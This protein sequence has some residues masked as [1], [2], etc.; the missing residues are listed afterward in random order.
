M[1]DANTDPNNWTRVG[2]GR[3]KN[4]ITGEVLTGQ[5]GNPAVRGKYSSG[6]G[7]APAQSAP[8]PGPETPASRSAAAA[9]T[10][11]GDSAAGAAA[12]SEIFR[13]F[14]PAPTPYEDPYRASLDILGG[15]KWREY[16]QAGQSSPELRN[17]FNSLLG[18]QSQAGQVDPT[19]QG[20]L[21]RLLAESQV[22]YTPEEI[23]RLREGEQTGFDRSVMGALRSAGAKGGAAGLQ[24]GALGSLQSLATQQY[25]RDISDME[26]R[27]F[28]DLIKRKDSKLE[29]AT[30]LSRNISTDKFNRQLL[31]NRDTTDAAYQMQ[32]ANR[33]DRALKFQNLYQITTGQA[34]RAMNTFKYNTD[35]LNAWRVADLGA[36]MTGGQYKDTRKD[37]EAA[38]DIQRRAVE[39]MG[40]GFGGGGGGGGGLDPLAGLG[41]DTLSDDAPATGTRDTF[42]TDNQGQQ[43]YSSGPTGGQSRSTG[44]MFGGTRL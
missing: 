5:A 23:A 6:S 44:T 40:G 33:Q 32:E 4:S 28:G 30:D 37:T 39:K 12:G 21:D 11:F 25:S 42:Y 31:T 35:A 3:Y 9:G 14:I 17:S 7:S 43:G 8:A 27:L 18:L 1:A 36:F 19:Q 29:A 2:G 20:I 22:G 15:Q 16:E 38:I 26:K 24:G 10:F 34:D 13:N 41:P